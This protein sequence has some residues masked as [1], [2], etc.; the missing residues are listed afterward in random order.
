[1][2]QPASGIP[3]LQPLLR[4]Y[5]DN[6]MIPSRLLDLVLKL[7]NSHLCP[8]YIAVSHHQSYRRLMNDLDL[9]TLPQHSSRDTPQDG[10][11][12]AMPEPAHG[13][14]PH[15]RARLFPAYLCPLTWRPHLPSAIFALMT[16]DIIIHTALVAVLENPL[17][18]R[19]GLK[20]ALMR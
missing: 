14:Q 18:E 1:M 20:V 2:P 9:T 3:D 4:S 6:H 7:P 13:T 17:L 16:A 15:G 11:S 8:Y 10:S 5:T 12:G 19:L